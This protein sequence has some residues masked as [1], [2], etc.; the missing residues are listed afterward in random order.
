MRGS[1]ARNPGALLG[2]LL[3]IG[4]VL[5]ALVYLNRP[6][7]EQPDLLNDRVAMEAATRRFEPESRLEELIVESYRD[8]ERTTELFEALLEAEVWVASGEDLNAARRDGRQTVSFQHTRFRGS[9]MLPIYTLQSRVPSNVLGSRVGTLP[10]TTILTSLRT[11]VPIVINP[12]DTLPRPLSLE[13]V[14][15]LRAMFLG[16]ATPGAGPGAVAAAAAAEPL[17]PAMPLSPAMPIEPAL[18]P[19]ALGELTSS[20]DLSSPAGGDA[21]IARLARRRSSRKS[22]AE[23]AMRR[24][25]PRPDLPTTAMWTP[26]TA[27]PTDGA[28][29]SDE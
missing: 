26:I 28:P 21:D 14:Q 29:P 8:P 22:K 16:E 23:S 24:R 3:P 12:G 10:F 27:S 1:I 13:E 17:E 25:T 5:A 9:Q 18:R 15:Q 20:L 11:P 4:A 6:E 19:E 2:I 7:P